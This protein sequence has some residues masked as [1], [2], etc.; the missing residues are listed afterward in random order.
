MLDREALLELVGD[1]PI[2]RDLN[3]RVGF[4]VPLAAVNGLG[5]LERI[6]EHRVRLP[7][8]MLDEGAPQRD[9]IDSFSRAIAHYLVGEIALQ[10]AIEVGAAEPS[11]ASIDGWE[12][13]ERTEPDFLPVR[14]RLRQVRR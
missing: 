1:G 4:S 7:S 13:A 6:L 14:N 8:T 12:A 3:P 10:R 11:Q 5:N 9:R 2:E